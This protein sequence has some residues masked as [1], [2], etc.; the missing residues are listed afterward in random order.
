MEGE[1]IPAARLGIEAV[2]EPGFNASALVQERQG[3]DVIGL[4]CQAARRHTSPTATSTPVRV[5][6]S[7]FASTTP[8]ALP[9]T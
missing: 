1:D 8:A 9:S 3:S 7:G 6:P 4:E 2:G 5:C